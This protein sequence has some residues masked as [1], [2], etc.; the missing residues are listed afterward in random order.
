M[1]GRRLLRQPTILLDEPARRGAY[2]VYRIA[3]GGLSSEIDPQSAPQSS[4]WFLRSWV[5]QRSRGL[6]W[7][8]RPAEPPGLT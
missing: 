7:A 3:Q 5:A 8:E 4:M 2:T 6:S 1:K